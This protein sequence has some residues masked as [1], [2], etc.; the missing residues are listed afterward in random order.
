MAHRSECSLVRRFTS[1][2]VES[3]PGLCEAEWVGDE[4][5]CSGSEK[6]WDGAPNHTLF[7]N[8]T[9]FGLVGFHSL[10]E[11]NNGFSDAL[12]IDHR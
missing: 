11:T 8:L 9:F 6:G 1:V 12:S 10:D 5:E 7:L 4:V 2:C 3:G